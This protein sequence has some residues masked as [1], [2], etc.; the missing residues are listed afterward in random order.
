M[1]SEQRTPEP[2]VVECFG[3]NCVQRSGHR[4][5]QNPRDSKVTHEKNNSKCTRVA[6]CS[7]SFPSLVCRGREVLLGDPA[8]KRLTTVHCLTTKTN[9]KERN[10][11]HEGSVVFVIVL[12]C[13][14]VGQVAVLWTQ[15]I[16]SFLRGKM[17]DVNSL[18]GLC[19]GA[20]TCR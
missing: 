6:A 9:E 11:I 8:S 14:V 7:L 1:T 2:T 5:C 10:A 20:L 3:N 16:S 17:S 12:R 13:C 15:A 18:F 19:Q 4:K